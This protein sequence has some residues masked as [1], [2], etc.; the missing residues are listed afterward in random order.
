MSDQHSSPIKT[1]KQLVTVVILAF[2]VPILIIAL[3]VKYVTGQ[4]TE[5]AGSNAMTPEA[6]ADR[7]S[8]VGVVAYQGTASAGG[9]PKTGEAV[10]TL[11]CAACHASGVAGAPKFADAGAWGPRNKQ[12][13]ETLVKHATEGFKGM[14]AKGGNSA[15]SDVEVARAVAY[16]ANAGGASYKEPAAA[17]APVPAAGAAAAG[18]ADAGKK[19]YEAS[20]QACHA[21]GVAGAPKFGDKA[22]WAPRIKTGLD[23]LLASVVKGKNAMP[24]KGGSSA[25]DAELKAAVEYMVNAAK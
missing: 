9:A 5:A 6:V 3:L 2:I 16:M 21:A 1:P 12:G 19:L 15:L 7:L 14:P 11:A 4:K 25:S 18:V 23:T 8:P 24:P 10:Y 13:F 22:A 17:G 20:C